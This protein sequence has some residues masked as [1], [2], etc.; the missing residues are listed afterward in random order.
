MS[1][2]WPP[3]PKR[4]RIE[5]APNKPISQTMTEKVWLDAL[6]G[7][8]SGLLVGPVLYFLVSFVTGMTYSRFFGK[9]DSLERQYQFIVWGVS[10]TLLTVIHVWLARKS[11]AFA[12]PMWLFGI[13]FF[14]LM[15]FM[16]Y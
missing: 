16:A 8:L 5:A 2:V 1:E 13:P 7:G 4:N 6:L 12:I 3:P 9:G 10:A 14:L 15:L 11:W